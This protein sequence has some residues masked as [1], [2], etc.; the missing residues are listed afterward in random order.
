M[1]WINRPPSTGKKKSNFMWY[2]EERSQFRFLRKK[3]VFDLKSAKK[4]VSLLVKPFPT[5][6]L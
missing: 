6:I 5:Y 1:I 2:F 4:G 3:K